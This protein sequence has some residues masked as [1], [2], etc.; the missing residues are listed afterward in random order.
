MEQSSGSVDYEVDRNE[1]VY[2]NRP[3]QSEASVGISKEYLQTRSRPYE[4]CKTVEDLTPEKVAAVKEIGWGHLLDLR[5]RILYG[6]IWNMV[7]RAINT[8]N[9]TVEICGAIFQVDN[10]QF[11]RVMGIADG[12]AEVNDGQ[13]LTERDESFVR[14][15]LYDEEGNI[16]IARLVEIVRYREEADYLFKMAFCLYALT[17]LLCPGREGIVNKGLVGAVLQTDEIGNKKWAS[18]AI[19]CLMEGVTSHQHSEEEY[20]SG[21]VVF[22]QLLYLDIVGEEF[23][24]VERR[25]PPITAWYPSVMNDVIATVKHH[26]GFDCPLVLI[27]R[28]ARQNRL[29]DFVNRDNTVGIG[30]N[31]SVHED[32]Y[33]SLIRM[34]G[35]EKRIGDMTDMYAGYRPDLD[36]IKRLVLTLVDIIHSM[37][38]DVVQ[39]VLEKGR[40]SKKRN[41]EANDKP[42][43]VGTTS[44]NSV[45]S[46]T[47]SQ[48]GCGNIAGIVRSVVDATKPNARRLSLEGDKGISTPRKECQAISA[49][50]SSPVGLPTR[51]RVERQYEGA[52]TKSVV[53]RGAARSLYNMSFT[54]EPAFDDIVTVGVDVF[55]KHDRHTGK[56]ES[57]HFIAGPYTLQF[58]LPDEDLQLLNYICTPGLHESTVVANV[59]G[60][61]FIIPRLHILSL[62][63]DTDLTDDVIN[64]YC[65]FLSRDSQTQWFLPTFFSENANRDLGER[66]FAVS[67]VITTSSVCNMFRF[68][69]RME[70]CETLAHLDEVLSMLGYKSNDVVLDL[71]M[72]EVVVPPNVPR[73]KG[74]HECGIYT[75]KNMQLYGTPWTN[76][77]NSHRMRLSM[78]LE[79]LKEP[80]NEIYYQVRQRAAALHEGTDPAVV[81]ID[82]PAPI[83]FTNG[84]GD[85]NIETENPQVPNFIEEPMEVPRSEQVTL[86]TNH[87]DDYVWTDWYSGME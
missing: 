78:M 45:H 65:A 32:L 52:Y 44:R 34:D 83:Q 4:F 5:I 41:R 9:R 61:R 60:G 40:T 85:R 76:N 15:R 33:E 59:H 22:L 23:N 6:P 30:I 3:S 19:S 20:V 87:H 67:R 72:C 55:N 86:S 12:R 29:N 24:L 42:C 18:Y 21:S 35:I 84:P 13:T 31:R 70:D 11:T 14:T 75:I 69:E 26:G 79:C 53:S 66:E 77:Y 71:N 56:Q 63:P 64:F 27:S 74:V 82:P 16:L 50:S 8:N 38:E 36:E 47:R 51:N 7:Y 73:Q 58:P 39:R 10:G 43:T 62:L 80:A 17:T 28:A 2:F 1:Q 25:L 68:S 37:Q 54:K 57:V 81:D 48:T 49:T 46:V